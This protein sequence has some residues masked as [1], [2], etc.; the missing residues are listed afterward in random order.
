M[1]RRATSQSFIGDVNLEIPLKLSNPQAPLYIET[2][3]HHWVVHY[4]ME[5]ALKVK[6]F[7]KLEQKEDLWKK[8][9]LGLKENTKVWW[10]FK[11]NRI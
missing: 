3:G 5:W 11:I 10:K 4:S 9:L 1:D 2:K 7:T 6:D 8:A